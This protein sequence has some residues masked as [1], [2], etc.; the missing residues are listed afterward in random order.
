MRTRHGVPLL[1]EAHLER[2]RGTCRL[3]GLP[4]PP[5]A[6]AVREDAARHPHPWGRYRLTV[7][8]HGVWSQHLPLPAVP[9][10]QRAGADVWLSGW[11]VHPQ[12]A[13][14]KTGNYLPYRLAALEAVGQGALEALLLS[15]DGGRV[16]DGSR[17]SPLL[18]VEGE[19]WV[20]SGGL[21]SVTRAALL[22][23]WGRPWREVE[24]R[25]E[26][27]CRA[28]HL[29][30]CGSGLGVL[31]VA[32]VRGAH[33]ALSFAARALPFEDERFRVPDGS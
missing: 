7:T 24:L 1:L 9:E 6:D 33:L 3:L 28:Q 14:H 11:R 15:S 32:R 29:W 26:D 17:S 27:L 19:L 10:A 25:P 30:L 18:E 16:A 4:D 8:A 20:P 21:Q 12:L 22:A 2:L 5:A 13:A 23:A 31:P